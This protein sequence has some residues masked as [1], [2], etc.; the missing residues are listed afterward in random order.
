MKTDCGRRTVNL[1]EVDDT[2]PHGPEHNVQEANSFLTAEKT[3]IRTP[4]SAMRVLVVT[5]M[6]PSPEQ[7][8][9]G[10]FVKNQVDDLRAADVAIDVLMINGRKNRWNYLWGVFRFWKQLLANRYD[11]I[12]CHY[13]F[14]GLIGRLQWRYPVILTHHGVEVVYDGWVSKLVRFTHRWFDKVIVVSQAQEDVLQDPKVALVPCGIDFDKMRLMPQHEARGILKLPLDQ[15]LVLW[16]G[17]FWQPVKRY[18]LVEKAMALVQEQVPEAKLIRVSGQPHS[19]MPY[20]MNAC[21]VLVLTSSYEG[22]PMVIKEAMAC[23]LPIVSTAAGDVAQVIE[24]TEGCSLCESTPEDVARKLMAVL[25]W[26]KRTCGR[27]RIRHLDS[28]VIA[29][30]VANLYEELCPTEDTRLSRLRKE[31]RGQGRPRGFRSRRTL[32]PLDDT[33]GRKETS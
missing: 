14:S 5:N 33:R 8:A 29:R 1:K 2:A 7:P 26:G 3:N 20:Y 30:R 9:F 12:H 11:L 13:I 25:S 22:S 27:Q 6:Y 21:D 32:V 10:T 31:K 17:E 4:L 24:G 19:M 16:A 18:Y 15:K 23:N 28:R